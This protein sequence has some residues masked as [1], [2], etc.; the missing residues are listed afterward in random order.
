MEQII[1]K[2][3]DVSD[4]DEYAIQLEDLMPTYPKQTDE[5]I[6]TEVASKKEFSELETSSTEDQPTKRGQ[7]F[8]HQEQFKRLMTT[9]CDSILLMH[10]TG[11]GKSCSIG[12]VA[13]EL[14]R[15]YI[16]Q[17]GHIN[18]VLFLAKGDTVSEEFV[19]QLVNV[20]TS[21]YETDKVRRSK[22]Q[23]ERKGKISKEIKPKPGNISRA[24]Q[25][26]Y[27]IKNWGAFSNK[28]NRMKEERFKGDHQGYIN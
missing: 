28:L 20:C 21:S 2:I 14:K 10:R 4:G 3:I 5:K 13:E 25:F 23:T 8:K 15:L 12:A 9:I 19:N 24:K 6:Q 17:K 22:T 26:G 11:T 16:E 18:K 7:L 27:L 1:D